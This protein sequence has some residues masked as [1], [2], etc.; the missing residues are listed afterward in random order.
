M[1]KRIG[2]LFARASPTRIPIV[3][4][5]LTAGIACAPEP[6]SIRLDG[7]LPE[8]LYSLDPIALPQAIA[9]DA[10]GNA[11]DTAVEL[12]VSPLGRVQVR[13]GKLLLHVPGDVTL[14]WRSGKE[15]EHSVSLGIR[16]IDSIELRCLPE[17]RARV[18]QE[19]RIQG[20]AYSNGE[21]LHELDVPLTVSGESA[22]LVANVL[23]A[24]R[25]GTVTVAG[26]LGSARAARDVVFQGRPDRV[27][28]QCRTVYT[29][30]VT[31]E[32][33]EFRVCHLT[34][35]LVARVSARA[36][37]GALVLPQER[38][39][40]TTLDEKVVT[41]LNNERVRPLRT[42]RTM[43]KAAVE[44]DASVVAQLG[45]DVSLAS[46]REQVYRARVTG[47]RRTRGPLG[48]RGRD[49]LTVYYSPAC[50]EWQTFT[51]PAYVDLPGTDETEQLYCAGSPAISCVA[52]ASAALWMRGAMQSRSM[53]EW[54]GPCCCVTKDDREELRAKERRP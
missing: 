5:C 28:L 39:V 1:D 8:R 29:K 13:D 54:L 48:L 4:A 38:V 35:D 3:V 32:G 49:E 51:S 12:T 11:L 18:G 14:T 43:L 33:D 52:E 21:L 9:L 19:V 34:K 42:G 15:V 41:V 24:S 22:S 50:P 6:A 40:L 30:T 16:P 46:A 26:V 37:S 10:A 47:Y 53:R 20:A 25:E 17:C 23:T 31:D 2:L 45:L 44:S 27:E 7:V 36:Y